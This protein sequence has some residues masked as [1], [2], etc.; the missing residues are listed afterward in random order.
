MKKLL[1]IS[2]LFYLGYI[3]FT[4]S[5]ANPGMPTGGV[6]DTIPPVVLKTVPD[7][8]VVNYDG[9]TVSLT[10]N[11]FVIS[12]EVSTKLLVS[13]PLKKKPLVRTKSKTL[14]VE[15]GDTLRENVT[16]VLDFR[17]AIADNN[18]KNP[19]DNFRFAFST[20]PQFDSLMIG[21]YVLTAVNMEPV[22]E[23][24][25]LLYEDTDSL[26]AFRKN[27][28]KYIA[29]TNEEGFYALTNIAAGKYRL[30]A[31]E[32]ADAS[33]TYNQSG[34]RI[35]F[36]DQLVVPVYPGASGKVSLDSLYFLG[37]LADS[38]KAKADSAIAEEGLITG[39]MKMDT[40]KSSE[41]I[42]PSGLD[43]DS[44]KPGRQA[45][46]VTMTP[47]YLLMFQEKTLEQFLDN[48]SRDQRNLI[49]IYFSNSVSDSFKVDL[50]SPKPPSPDWSYLEY[51]TTRDSVSL[52]ITDTL[53]S[54][55]DTLNLRVTYETLDSLDHPALKADTLELVYTDP[56][57]RGRRKK[58]KEEAPVVQNFSFR[59]NAQDGFDP[60]NPV[61]IESPEPIDVFDFSKVHLYQQVDT[62]E[63]E[64]RFDIRQDSIFK[65]KFEILYQW[66][67]EQSYR[68]AIDSA[69][70]KNV[71]GGPSNAV[72]QK[73]KIQKEDYYGK[74]FIDIKKT[75]GNCIIQL[76]KNTE[77][78]EVRKQVIIRKDSIA[79]FSFVKPEKYKV[80]LIV[81]RNQNGHWDAGDLD[82]WL[83]PERVVYY[84]KIL[85]IR[86]NFEVHETWMLP[87]DLHPKKELIDEDQKAEDKKKKK[88]SKPA[89]RGLR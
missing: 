5:C 22:E 74:I 59:I 40:L 3:V 71:T 9:N 31:L 21:G 88:G 66:E 27:I 39:K 46:R 8:N 33:L 69:A 78:E 20:G 65:R 81:D 60:Y 72:D 28:P 73:F 14:T 77:L 15:L 85:K 54:R 17:D 34:E 53:V 82:K 19:L 11:E 23:A 26:S 61:V 45:E 44:L 10:F 32:D 70:A 2:V 4:T 83:Q 67:F 64:I 30:F 35:A 47:H 57:Q 55:V 41:M 79:V 63:E 89:K 24:T 42:I 7:M 38:L 58:N 48:S 80:K 43:A 25:V 87:D 84:P 76:L 62:L 52:W 29:K 12:D 75:P 86:S 49:K 51:N 36:Y 1:I 13:P 37:D 18:E 50:I 6:K 56:V 68:L 16:Y